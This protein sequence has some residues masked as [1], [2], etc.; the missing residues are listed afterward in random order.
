[1][2]AQSAAAQ[3]PAAVL[4]SYEARLSTKEQALVRRVRTALRT[5]F[6]TAN[7]LAYDYGHQI[8]IAYAPND[9]GSDALVSIV[10]K[11]DSVLLAFTQGR[12]LPDPTRLLLGAGQS[13]AIPVN[14]AAQLNTP[15]VK[16]LLAAA[17][18]RATVPLPTTGKGRLIIRPTAAAKRAALKT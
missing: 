13:R 6:P 14:S 15:A 17:V 16:A 11:P 12:H 3:S 5:R 9:R 7:E 4:R 8:V 2:P 1:M 18:A 10:A